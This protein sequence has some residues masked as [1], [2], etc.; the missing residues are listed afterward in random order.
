M[1]NKHALP[2]SL[3]NLMDDLGIGQSIGRHLCSTFFNS[4]VP[5]SDRGEFRHVLSQLP[6]I[7]AD[8]DCTMKKELV[9]FDQA[10]LGKLSRVHCGSTVS[11]GMRKDVFGTNVATRL[12]TAST[13]KILPPSFQ[14]LWQ[15]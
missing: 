8:D 4:W 2:T 13:G 3:L 10:F 1:L 14:E 9:N 5:I 6:L 7:L 11:F 12:S 15:E